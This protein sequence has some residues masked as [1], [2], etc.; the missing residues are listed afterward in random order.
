MKLFQGSA[1]NTPLRFDQGA[2]LEAQGVGNPVTKA[3]SHHLAQFSFEFKCFETRRAFVKVM[4]NLGSP[5]LGQL[6][7]EKGI[8]PGQHFLAFTSVF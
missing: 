1:L 7:V 3:I 6:A 8:K 5:L 2:D 4:P